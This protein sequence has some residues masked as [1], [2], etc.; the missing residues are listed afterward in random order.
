MSSETTPATEET[1]NLQIKPGTILWKGKKGSGPTVKELSSKLK[2]I[3][4]DNPLADEYIIDITSQILRNCSSKLIPT[5]LS[6]VSCHFHRHPDTK[7]IDIHLLQSLPSNHHNNVCGVV[8]KKG[9]LAWVCRTCG[10][11]QTCVQCDK[12][13]RNSDHQ[14]HEVFFHRSSGNG[15]CCDW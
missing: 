5:L 10:K 14:G 8:F 3:D 6:A 2:I 13:F 12:C 1:W 15:G 7:D 4:W 11:D 9:D